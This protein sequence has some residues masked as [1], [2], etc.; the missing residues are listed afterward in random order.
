VP[1]LQEKE[2]GVMEEEREGG[3]EGGRERGG[4][5]ERWER[6]ST[7]SEVIDH[8]TRVMSIHIIFSR[9]PANAFK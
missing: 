8:K 5:G 1:Q 9:S 2:E 6:D 7:V 3:R 4:G